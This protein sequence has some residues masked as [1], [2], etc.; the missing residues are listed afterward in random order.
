VNNRH[1]YILT[2][3]LTLAGLGIFTYKTVV[4]KFPLSP[5]SS[6]EVWDI[7]VRVGFYAQGAP[8][9]VRLYV[10]E[11][12]ENY[13]M[14]DE[15]LV[16]RG[17]GVRIR[18]LESNRQVVWSVRKAS[19]QQALYYRVTM[20]KLRSQQDIV[21][22]RRP[23]I[24]KSELQ[25][26]RLA[27]AQAIVAQIRAQ[28]ADLETLVFELIKR[29]HAPGSDEDLSLLLGA[30]PN[31][32]QKLRVA[33]QI[34]QLAG[35]PARVVHGIK[36][37]GLKRNL[38][39][40]HW[41]QIYKKDRWRTFNQET[42]EPGV[43]EDYFSWWYGERPLVQ[44]KNVS[45]VNTNIAVAL[46]K[47]AAIYGVPLQSKTLS[48]VLH[49]F[50]LFSLPVDKQAIYHVLLLIPLGA[51]LLVIMR[52]V[53]GIQTFGTFMPILIALS[54]RETQLIYGII[55]FCIVIGLG[56]MLR[57]YLDRL[58]LLLVPRLASVLIVVLMLMAILSIIS[59]NLGFESGLSVALFPMVIMTMTIERMSIVWEE[60]GPN[61]AMKQV[62]GSLIV[63]TLAY[64][65]M[66]NHFMGH[67]VFI[68][69]E[70][71]LIVLAIT[72]L[73]GRYSGYRLLELFRFR[74]LYRGKR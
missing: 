20:Q 7:E 2:F 72:L 37:S 18:Q 64:M 23:E 69:P 65:V 66:T 61:E 10:P 55:L 62:I 51:L 25:G 9:K 58:K 42:G 28:S 53:I 33:V 6:S 8:V 29:L 24:K 70:L 19:G 35:V 11:T 54:F 14:L 47:T 3:L 4:L 52:N 31:P 63:A 32:L 67:I 49:K 40:I 30:N 57:L 41:L 50:S 71:L 48:P 5:D 36:L 43:P 16:S 15:N 73:L 34:L 59:N 60:R 1:L 44:T 12:S 74:E 46:N 13:T 56:L 21:E 39:V 27:G 38:E 22:P 26:A 45:R 17:Y 68:F